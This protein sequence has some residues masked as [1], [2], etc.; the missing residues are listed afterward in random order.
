[1]RIHIIRINAM[2]VYIRMYAGGGWVGIRE[3]VYMGW[4]GARVTWLHEA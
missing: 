2:I 4:G 1:M 3:C